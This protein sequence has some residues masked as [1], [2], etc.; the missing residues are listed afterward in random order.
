M[1]RDIY[2]KKFLAYKRQYDML[3]KWMYCDMYNRKLEDALLAQGIHSIMIYGMGEIGG[4]VYDKLKDTPIQI[5]CFIDSFSVA[6]KY[7]LED[8]D[9]IKPTDIQKRKA[10]LIIISLPQIAESIEADLLKLGVTIPIQS[11]EHII[12]KM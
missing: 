5:E 9:V 7:Y 3:Y 4:I 2:Y 10:D 6:K 8:I 11:I 12:M 1:V